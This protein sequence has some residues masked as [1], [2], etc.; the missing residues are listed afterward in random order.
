[1]NNSED[2]AQGE[3]PPYKK[4]PKVNEDNV[5]PIS[6]T[7][8]ALDMP[9]CV[10]DGIKRHHELRLKGIPKGV[11]ADGKEASGKDQLLHLKHGATDLQCKQQRERERKARNK[12]EARARRTPEEMEKEKK[13]SGEG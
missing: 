5:I 13:E 8:M 9:D 3:R 12:R 4:K 1:M 2:D 7:T 11:K 6:N 10:D